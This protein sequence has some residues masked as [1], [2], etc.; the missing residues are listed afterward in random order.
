MAKIKAKQEAPLDVLVLGQHPASYLAAALLRYKSKLRVMH[1]MLPGPGLTDRLVLLS[2]ELFELHTI[3]SGLDKKLKLQSVNGLRF[4]SDDAQ[5]SSEYQSKSVV[6]FIGRFKDVCDEV[7]ELARAQGVELTKP[8][9]IQIHRL[10]EHGI[11][12][13]LG[14]SSLRAR[15]LILGG[16]LPREQMALLGLPE[17]WEDEV[18]HRFT[19]VRCKNGK[20]SVP[21]EP[22][23]IPMSL[24]LQGHLFWAWFL[25]ADGEFQLQIEQPIETVQHLNGAALLLHWCDVLKS[26]GILSSN[27]SYQNGAVKSIDLPLGGALVHEGVANRTLLVGPAGGFYSACGEDVYPN[28]WS[29]IFAAEVMKKAL[30]EEHLQDA[31]NAYRSKWRTTL[32]DYLRGPQQNLRFLLPLVYRNPAMTSRL[33]EA[34][35]FSKSV[36]R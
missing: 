14:N 2:P 12:L 26:R 21:R 35:L 27:F 3:L 33:A 18:I 31:L 24:D 29:A 6:A 8:K 23:V 9:S 5:I 17:P 16:D 22:R 36:V 15:A 7:V 11:D 4:L 32:G 28:C 10:D 1:A 30:G 13:T 20:Q 25:E 34:I 19:F